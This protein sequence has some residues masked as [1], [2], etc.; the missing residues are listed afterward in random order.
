MIFESTEKFMITAGGAVWGTAA[1]SLHSA[2]G[3]AVWG[4]TAR[5]LHSGPDEP[6]QAGGT[7]SVAMTAWWSLSL[8]S[9]T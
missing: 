1:R 6:D 8:T 3:R 7:T 2:A 5:S 4:T 9:T